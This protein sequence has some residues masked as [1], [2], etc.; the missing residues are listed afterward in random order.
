MRLVG[1]LMA[2]SDGHD[3]IAQARVAAFRDVLQGLG[4]AAGRNVRFEIRWAAGDIERARTFSAE[5]VA[6]APDVILASGTTAIATLKQA[7][8][9]IPLV[10]V[11]VNDP[12][13]QG[14]VSS[15]AHPGGNIT[16]FSYM[17]YS[18]IG[19][20]LQLLKQVAP[21]LSR[22]GFMFNPDAYPY[23]EVYLKSLDEHHQ[24]YGSDLVP[25]RVRSE[26]EI[27]QAFDSLA[28]MPDA[29]LMVPPEPFTSS[30]RKLIVELAAQYRLPASYGLRDYVTDG[31]MMCYAPN[32]LDIYERSG[33][34]I[35]RVLK[36]AKPSELPVQAPTRFELSI[37]LKAVKAAG[38]SIPPAILAI[39][40][41]VIE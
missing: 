10:F 16:G 9:S 29:G 4:W 28:A 35:D 5:L 2:G 15:V 34:Y 21:K 37:N 27:K 20:A 33:A 22:V 3:Q 39:A 25:L 32:I 36:G 7:T 31:G 23:Y 13:A 17:D 24:E 11:I 1:V 14:F 40:D 18:V 41:D 30:H 6:L 26:A 8:S 19:K 38:L 12:V